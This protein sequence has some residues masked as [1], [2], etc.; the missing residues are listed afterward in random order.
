MVF[1]WSRAAELIKERNPTLVSAWLDG[2]FEWTECDIYADGKP[3]LD[4]YTYLASMWA[5][6]TINVD[7]MRSYCYKLQSEAPDWDAHTRWPKEA[8]QILEGK[9]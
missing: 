8:L 5:P 3:V 6:P 1:D 7:G 4:G 2:D 9:L